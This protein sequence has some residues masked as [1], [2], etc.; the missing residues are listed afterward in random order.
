M[1]MRDV[2]P[3]CRACVHV[4]AKT[5]RVESMRTCVCKDWKGGK[6]ACICVQRLE[7]YRACA[8]VCAKTGRVGSIHRPGKPGFSRPEKVFCPGGWCSECT[9]ALEG[10]VGAVEEGG[11]QGAGASILQ[12]RDL[13]AQPGK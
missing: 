11:R 12:G 9:S 5:G 1:W 7:R 13:A 6:H 8:H 3:G 2:V 4:C 10:M